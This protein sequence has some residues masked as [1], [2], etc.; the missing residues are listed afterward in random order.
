MSKGRR[1]PYALDDPA[2][3]APPRRTGLQPPGIGPRKKTFPFV[4]W[5]IPLL[6]LGGLYYLIPLALHADAVVALLPVPKALTEI[7][8]RVNNQENSLKP[9][10]TLVVNPKDALWINEKVETDGAIAWGTRVVF[11][12]AQ[13]DAMLANPVEIQTFWP[14]ESFETPKR[15]EILVKWL[16]R[17]IGR[18]F[19]S[20]ELD[21][22]DWLQKANAVS[23]PEQKLSYLQKVLEKSPDD[24]LVKTQ[25]AGLCFDLKKYDD[26][27]RLYGEIAQAGKTAPILEKLLA[28]H[29]KQNR[30][31]DALNDYLDLLPISKNP[32]QFKGLLQYLQKHKSAAETEKFIR[33]H[34]EKVPAG[35]QSALDLFIAG[36]YTQAKDW[37]KAAA[38]YEKAVRDGVKDPNILYNLAA[39]YQHGD[40]PGQAIPALQRYLKSSPD[41]LKTWMQLGALQESGGE[42]AQARATYETVLQKSPRNEEALTHLVALLEKSKDKS[43]LE[44]AYEKLCQIQPSNKVAHHNLAI[45][46]YESQK[47]DKATEEFKKLAALDPKDLDA[48]KFLLDIYRKT[49]NQAAEAEMLQSLVQIDRGNIEYY[50]VLCASLD[51]KKDYKAM[52]SLLQ[53]GLEHNPDSA[54]LHDY[55]L[56][57]QLKLGDKKAAVKELEHLIRLQ[58]NEKKYLKQAAKLHEA[59]GEYSEAQKTLEKLLKLD[60]SKENKDDYLRITRRLLEEKKSH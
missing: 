37:S 28:V 55:M 49:K 8:V 2:S 43:A 12:D 11:P 7:H 42:Q 27:G 57:A 51:E 10:S 60:N 21:S 39:S 35:F 18:V 25:M 30:V 3:A 48:R 20:I 24:V 36:V 54:P 56:L 46:F 5:L 19:L 44:G 34:R 53:K 13:M 29:V 22:R 59:L 31:D 4:K 47:W 26:A 6:L 14:Q 16:D 32:E 45:L 40:N 15:L 58:P 41:D 17:P 38:S 50:K 9:D 33:D 52:V 1:H 23:D